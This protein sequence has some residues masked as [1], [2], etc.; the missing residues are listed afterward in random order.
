[1][2][3]VITVINNRNRLVSRAWYKAH[4]LEMRSARACSCIANGFS[5]RIADCLKSFFLSDVI[6][7]S[8]EFE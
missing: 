7:V 4:D 8:I 3:H 1:M 6:V 5:A 2:I